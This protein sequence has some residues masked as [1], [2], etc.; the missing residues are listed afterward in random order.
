M[1]AE[2]IVWVDSGLSFASTWLEEETIIE[3]AKEWDGL[4]ISVGQV[5]YEDAERVVLGLSKDKETNNWTGAFLI[6]KPTIIIR[7]LLS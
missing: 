4:V 2:R 1:R 3:R 5:V 6:Y 7:K